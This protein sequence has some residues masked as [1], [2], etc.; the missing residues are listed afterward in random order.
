[1]KCHRL[2]VTASTSNH[3]TKPYPKTILEIDDYS[4]VIAGAVYSLAFYQFLDMFFTM[5][6]CLRVQCVI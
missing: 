6:P 5:V 1:M 3:R 2:E 4:E